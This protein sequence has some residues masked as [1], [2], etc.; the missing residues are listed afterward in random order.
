M[1]TEGFGVTV[2]AVQR[3]LPR[4]RDVLVRGER[5]SGRTC[6]LEALLTD[7]SRRGTTA[8]LLR[9]SGPGDLAALLDHAS[10][11][12]RTPD[13]TALADWLVEELPTRRSLLLVDDADRVDAGSLA[14]V[15]RVL[16]RTPCLLVATTTADPLLHGSAAL[17]EVLLHRPPAVVRVQPFGFRAVS[18]L[19]AAV[20]GAPADAGL[21]AAVMAQTGGN[22]RA[23]VALADAARASGAV[24]RT[25]GLWVDAGDAADVPVEAVAFTF[26]AD[27]P[28]EH[29]E[30]LELL[31]ATGPV[32]AEVADLLVPA[33]VLAELADAGR[34]VSHE[35]PG[36]GE[37]LGVAPPAL[38]HALRA[39]VGAV[40]RRQLA[41]RVTAAAGAAFAPVGPRQDDLSAVLLREAPGQ[42][43][44]YWR[45]TAE[46]A[47]LVRE[48]ATVE[49]AARRSAWVAAPTLATA[50]AYLAL[51]MRRPATEQLA[52]VFA[53]THPGARDSAE[54]RVLHAYYRMRWAAWA[55]LPDE[56][57]EA[58]IARV[59]A[60]LGPLL[61]LRDLKRRLVADL[62]AGRPPR[63]LAD[64]RTDAPSLRFLRGWPEV[65][66]AAAL[67]EAGRPA[68]ALRACGPGAPDGAD[69][70]VVHYRAALRGESLLMSGRIDEAEQWE[71]R[72]L[73]AA[74]D[75]VDAL[76][77]RVHAC[78]L[79]EV[80]YFA[81]QP[82]A[83]WRVVSTSLRLGAAGPIETTFHRRGLTLGA[84]LQ[85]H[86]GNP[87]LAQV[88]LRELDKTPQSYHP[89]VRSLRVLAHVALA[90]VSGDST[91]PGQTAWQAGQRY[92]EA[93]LLQ[94]ALLAWV[95]GPANLTPARAATVR[96]V[97][98]RTSVPLLEP[99]VRLLL[100]VADRDVEEVARHL[101]ATRADVAPALVRA[102]EDLLG[103]APADPGGA[104][105]R[106][107]R[108]E[109]LSGREQE[110]AVLA[111]E[112]LTNRQI[113]DRLYLSV[114]TVENHMS[115]AL[116]KLGYVTRAE[117]AGWRAG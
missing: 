73:D 97:L 56:D 19:L 41:A 105:P 54:D 30:G 31:A 29:V 36:S 77:I 52:A 80:L 82:D 86:A 8:V 7:A 109:P 100:A 48:R 53:G 93:G 18:G 20:L 108:V 76:G 88:L 43:D 85:A 33:P 6:V 114:R 101:A 92:A 5:G 47:G 46:L 107:V 58:G 78:V 37:V 10:A 24:R 79:A 81:G 57:A 3:W 38:A 45:W 87:P 28:R 2:R 23:V 116:R 35:T 13:A 64:E 90:T 111:R 62:A 63:E 14:V 83:A 39:R 98:A 34:V 95:G 106:L 75:A 55:G 102:G 21:T 94:P 91:A 12:V 103:I 9:A 68:E 26:L 42:D 60:D 32:P 16:G 25:D 61:R 50:N 1:E 89:L 67:L 15:R 59:G 71:R 65:V 72:L 112:G 69:P 99:Y 70:E 113:A 44:A 22:P 17:R 84:V 104:R 115:R 4:G 96:E 49:E 110:V 74:S 40:R 117:L 51:L 66:R 27:A 11:P